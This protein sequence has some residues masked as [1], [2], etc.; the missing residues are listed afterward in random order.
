MSLVEGLRFGSKG[1]GGQM[2]LHGEAEM[3]CGVLRAVGVAGTSQ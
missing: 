2:R 1:T 3:V